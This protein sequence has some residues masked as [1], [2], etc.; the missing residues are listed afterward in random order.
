MLSWDLISLQKWDEFVDQYLSLILNQ[1]SCQP[2]S[3]LHLKPEAS[4]WL[5]VVPAISKDVDVLL[6]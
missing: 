6:V 2:I 1:H 5:N 3:A 4:D